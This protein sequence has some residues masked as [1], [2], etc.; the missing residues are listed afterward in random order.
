MTSRGRRL[1]GIWVKDVKGNLRLPFTGIARM[2]WGTKVCV[3]LMR[4]LTVC[5]CAGILLILWG[6]WELYLHRHFQ[7]YS[8]VGGRGP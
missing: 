4:T 8:Y 6:Q 5:V 3:L 2:R 7:I 1:T